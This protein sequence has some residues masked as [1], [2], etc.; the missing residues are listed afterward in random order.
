V[1][2]NSCADGE[3]SSDALCCLPVHMKRL[4]KGGC[5]LQDVRWG[6]KVKF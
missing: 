4:S 3:C 5:I 1:L 2:A 6:G